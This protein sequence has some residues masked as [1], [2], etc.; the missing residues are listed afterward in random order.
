MKEECAFISSMMCKKGF[1][2]LDPADVK[3]IVRGDYFFICI[4]GQGNYKK[5]FLDVLYKMPMIPYKRALIQVEYH[6]SR[7][8]L[9]SEINLLTERFPPFNCSI[10]FSEL[11]K[12]YKHDVVSVRILLSI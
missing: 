9:F 6:P 7:E 8:P 11:P 5:R 12:R 3:E 4:K 2:Q 10:G 1:L